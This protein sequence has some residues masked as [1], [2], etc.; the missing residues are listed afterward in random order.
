MSWKNGN[1]EFSASQVPKKVTMLPVRR[2][3][4]LSGQKV[5]RCLFV[6]AGIRDKILMDAM[7]FEKILQ[8]CPKLTRMD[9]LLG[10][11]ELFEAP[12]SMTDETS[13]LDGREAQ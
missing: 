13:L 6:R 2:G 12:P 1:E 5:L 3:R 4:D 10:L 7:A 8:P 9:G 11:F